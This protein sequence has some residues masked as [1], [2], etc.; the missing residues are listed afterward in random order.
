MNTK[1]HQEESRVVLRQIEE[2]RQK[3]AGIEARAWSDSDVT[4]FEN[5]TNDL[6]RIEK[7]MTVSEQSDRIEKALNTE[8]PIQLFRNKDGK[9]ADPKEVKFYNDFKNYLITAEMTP[10]LKAH[11]ADNPAAG[12]FL[13]PPMQ[14]VDQFVVNLKNNVWMRGMATVFPLTHG[15]SMGAP[16][17]DTDIAD[18]TWTA[19]I[20]SVT[21]TSDLAFG[22]RELKPR[23]IA[24]LVKISRRLL[25][26]A[27]NAEAIIMDRMAYKFAIVEENAFLNGTGSEQPL[28]VFTASSQGVTTSQDTTCANATSV[29]ADD[30][31]N[32][33]HNTKAQYWDKGAWIFHRDIIKAAR[34]LKDNNNNYIWA[35]GFGPGLGFQGNAPSILDRPYYI[36]E[37]APNTLT[38]GLYVGI[39]GD[40]SK[41][42][43]C[44][45][46]NMEIQV[47]SELYA[48]TSQYGYIGRRETDGMPVLAEAFQRMKLA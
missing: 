10:E 17:L 23:Q 28:G 6:E 20:S 22:R 47:L 7:L 42:W 33:K 14:W 24:Q 5:L 8:V 36:S 25:R 19:E 18:P 1:A 35:T 11:Q 48:A 12:G 41:Y 4:T 13:I 34:K 39:F 44:D 27:P 16:A 46:L 30:F 21:E 40:F 26:Q 9:E 32:C 3:N 45:A 37:Y 2:I 29:V 43:I 31:I 15:E 38:T